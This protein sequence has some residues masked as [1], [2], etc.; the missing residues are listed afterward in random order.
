[1]PAD[2]HIERRGEIL[3][4]TLDDPETRNAI[5]RDI[6]EKATAAFVDAGSDPSVRAVV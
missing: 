1:M 6:Y 4:L 3:L 5:A 2:I